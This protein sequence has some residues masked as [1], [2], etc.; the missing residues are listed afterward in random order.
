M[1]ESKCRRS[2]HN[3]IDCKSH[4]T[5]LNESHFHDNYRGRFHCYLTAPG[6]CR[7]NNDRKQDSCETPQPPSLG[8]CVRLVEITIQLRVFWHVTWLL[9]AWKCGKLRLNSSTRV[10]PPCFSMQKVQLLYPNAGQR[11]THEKT[12]RTE[13]MHETSS[14][15]CTNF[16]A[17]EQQ[18]ETRHTADDC[19]H[20]HMLPL[21]SASHMKELT[22]RTG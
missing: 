10:L 2:Y 5:F 6:F 19:K 9:S 12:R 17:G 11:P 7:Y 16:S 22:E 14:S 1:Q 21:T 20:R 3:S 13:I 8:F 15:T 4:S 18:Y